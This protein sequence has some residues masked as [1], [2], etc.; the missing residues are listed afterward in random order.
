MSNREQRRA[1]EAAARRARR[2][3]GGAGGD[4]PVVE[5]AVA[6]AR[7]AERPKTVMDAP[8]PGS[9][10]GMLERR[11]GPRQRPGLDP[12]GQREPGRRVRR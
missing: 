8:E 4:S 12:A 9:I 2:R 6:A 1:Q 11:A 10:E 5:A 3:N 7:N